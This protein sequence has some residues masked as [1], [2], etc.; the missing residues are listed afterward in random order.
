M[1]FIHSRSFVIPSVV[2]LLAVQ[3]HQVLGRAE[4]GGSLKPC[5]NGSAGDCAST[6]AN[7]INSAAMAAPIDLD[8]R[9]EPDV[10]RSTAFRRKVLHLRFTS[11][12][13]GT[14][15]RCFCL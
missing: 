10:V 6:W 5:A 3:C 11:T 9:I 4:A 15:N 2:T 7:D 13:G 1:R 14:P 12:K 8:F